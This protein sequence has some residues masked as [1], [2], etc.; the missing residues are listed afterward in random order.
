[1]TSNQTST[2]RHNHSTFGDLHGKVAVITG[3]SSL[4]AVATADV[5]IR[6]G[7][8]VALAARNAENIGKVAKALV[9]KGGK[10]I[11]VPADVTDFASLET[12]RDEAETQLGATDI[13]I[14]LAGGNG[15][16]ILATELSL[17]VWRETLDVNLTG[18]FLTLKAFLPGMISRRRGSI[19]T[20]ASTAGR[21][22]S[23]ASPAYGAAKAGVLMLMRQIAVQTGEYGV[24]VN[25][26]APGAVIEG[27]QMP[28]EMREQLA[29]LH[30]LRRTGLAADVAEATLFLAS[31]ASSWI[32]GSTMDVNGG[33]IML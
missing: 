7:V 27:K 31:D 9:A 11:A 8:S 18:T 14:T 5:L 21:Q 4:I 10:A 24:R 19:I 22:V 2:A 16:P 1:M 17:E 23:P 33:R 12:L 13:L 32:T 3:G 25:A 29:H 30:P 6:N 15:K 26:I 28:D 20:M